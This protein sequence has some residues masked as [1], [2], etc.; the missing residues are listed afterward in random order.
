MFLKLR[1]HRRVAWLALC[2]LLFG[3]LAPSLAQAAAAFTGK[4]W[5]EICSATGATRIQ[6]DADTDPLSGAGGAPE[7]CAFL[8]LLQHLPALADAA[9]PDLPATPHSCGAV[10]VCAID[11]PPA[12]LVFRDAHPSHAPPRLS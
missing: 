11:S 6:V 3:S 9:P 2:A 10:F 4:S 8:L 12:A 7:Q 1:L 5:V